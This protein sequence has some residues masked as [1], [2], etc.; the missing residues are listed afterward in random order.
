VGIY[1]WSPLKLFLCKTK[2]S[3]IL[4]YDAWLLSLQP[5]PNLNIICA[6]KPR[7][8]P[9]ARLSWDLG[10]CKP[11]F[12]GAVLVRQRQNYYMLPIQVNYRV[13]FWAAIQQIAFDQNT[14][15]ITT[16]TM[17][18]TTINGTSHKFCSYTL[19]YTW[20]HSFPFFHYL[21]WNWRANNDLQDYMVSYPTHPWSLSVTYE[22]GSHQTG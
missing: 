17:Y 7:P 15:T 13:K 3:Q 1:F 12:T 16:K 18:D 4:L 10:P 11:V 6:T 20:A 21:P 8:G 14:D 19:T 2:M 9:Q 5:G 22:K